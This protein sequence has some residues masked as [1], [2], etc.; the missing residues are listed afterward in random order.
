MMF[1]RV[2]TGPL[3]SLGGDPTA[4]PEYLAAESLFQQSD[5]LAAAGQPRESTAAFMAALEIQ[6]AA[7]RAAR[8]RARALAGNVSDDVW[9]RVFSCVQL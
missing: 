2:A 4:D 7:S 8:V 5:V 3:R 9:S 1:E 6:V